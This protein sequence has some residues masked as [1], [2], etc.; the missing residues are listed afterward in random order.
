MAVIN[1]ISVNYGVFAGISIT[2]RI[3]SIRIG[4][5]KFDSISTSIIHTSAI[6]ICGAVFDPFDCVKRVEYDYLL[7]KHEKLE[8]ELKT[9]RS[10]Y[11]IR[12]T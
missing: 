7:K 2:N 4:D 9:I 11:E 10:M 1:N 8:D 12:N 3:D 6:N 5:G